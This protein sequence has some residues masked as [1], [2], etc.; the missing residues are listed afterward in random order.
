MKLL[1]SVIVR[2]ADDDESCFMNDVNLE[3][4]A[5]YLQYLLPLA[6]KSECSAS[7]SEEN[8]DFYNI[9][10]WL[11][12]FNIL[13]EVTIGSV[14]N[15]YGQYLIGIQKPYQLFDIIARNRHSF[16]SSIVDLTLCEDILVECSN[17]TRDLD[18]WRLIYRYRKEW[19]VELLEKYDGEDS[20]LIDLAAQ[21][22]F[23]LIKSYAMS[24]DDSKQC[25][26]FS[27]PQETGSNENNQQNIRKYVERI[28]NYSIYRTTRGIQIA[29]E[30]L[31]EEIGQEELMI[32]LPSSSSNSVNKSESV[33]NTTERQ[34]SVQYNQQQPRNYNTTEEVEDHLTLISMIEQQRED[35][36]QCK[37]E[38]KFLEFQLSQQQELV[39]SLM[40]T[41]KTLIN[42]TNENNAEIKELKQAIQK[43]TDQ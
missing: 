17:L 6:S 1:K 20:A 31:L 30:N 16:D 24:V 39:M 33:F 11:F 42:K 9:V 22:C 3:N 43:L 26:L 13:K 7:S 40:Q 38:N 29:L 36:E 19:L 34:N 2:D 12:A 28:M 35:I 15:C 23:E 25:Y 18:Q 37:Q 5:L 14:L 4:Y 21:I 10:D 8:E 27:E 41:I 32:G